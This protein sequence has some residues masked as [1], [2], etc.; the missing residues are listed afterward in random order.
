MPDVATRQCRGAR[1]VD[2]HGTGVG[3]PA[4]RCADCAGCPFD[5]AGLN[6]GAFPPPIDPGH[7]DVWIDRRPEI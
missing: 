2:G 4:P 1:L 6:W 5:R 3:L 7:E